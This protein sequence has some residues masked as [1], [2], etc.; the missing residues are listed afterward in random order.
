MQFYLLLL[1]LTQNMKKI[2][3][4]ILILA[5][6]LVIGLFRE[7][8]QAELI[9]TNGFVAE[10]FSIGQGDSAY[11]RGEDGYEVVV[12]GG[13][14]KTILTKLNQVMA[15][16]DNEIDLLILTHPHSDH[17]NGLVAILQKYKV[18]QILMTDAP[19]TSDLYFSWL[20]IIKEKQIKVTDPKS[21]D[22]IQ[23]GEN[24]SFFVLY[25]DKSYLENEI[26]NLNLTSLVGILHH[27]QSSFLMMGDA[28]TPVQEAILKLN[29]DISARVYKFPHHGSSNGLDEV[30]IKRVN[31]EFVII[32]AGK[33]NQFNHPNKITVDFLK[34][35]GAKF[36]ITYETGD[37]VFTEDLNTQ[38]LK[39][40]TQF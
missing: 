23:L 9:P 30:F 12:D 38:N 4:I 21:G 40:Q 15:R 13:P 11:F 16:G 2:S 8:F 22:L 25:P 29:F 35:F 26:S 1:E 6:F 24:M 5:L 18:N 34:N 28:E 39:V 14:D 17:L 37:I 31:P 10:F 36:Y 7:N 20:E 19:H 33:N 3:N 27:N 32:S